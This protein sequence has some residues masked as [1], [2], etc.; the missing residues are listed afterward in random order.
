MNTV[1][2]TKKRLIVLVLIFLLGLVLLGVL[3]GQLSKNKAVSPP[4]MPDKGDK[5]SFGNRVC[6]QVITP[7]RNPQTG[8]C[9]EFPTPCDVPE[10]WEEVGSCN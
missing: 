7:A 9:K 8:E 3:Y 1:F 4:S 10:E 5:G 6:I 2:R